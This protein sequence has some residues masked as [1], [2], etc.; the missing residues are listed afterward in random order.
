MA[1]LVFDAQMQQLEDLNI[2]F[3]RTGKPL[4]IN[5]FIYLFI[6]TYLYTLAHSE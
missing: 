6:K 4:F 3:W 2:E 5:G 1:L